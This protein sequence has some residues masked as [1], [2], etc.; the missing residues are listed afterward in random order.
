MGDGDVVQ[1]LGLHSS[2]PVGEEK[3]EFRTANG[4]GPKSE[5][6]RSRGN[7]EIVHADEK[8]SRHEN[9]KLLNA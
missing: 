5:K 6:E 7:P 8:V 3:W 1:V 9:G 2:G 4:W